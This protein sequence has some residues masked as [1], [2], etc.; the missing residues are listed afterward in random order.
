MGVHVR[1]HPYVG[2]TFENDSSQ[3]ADGAKKMH[4]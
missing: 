2:R 4:W 3:K 1:R